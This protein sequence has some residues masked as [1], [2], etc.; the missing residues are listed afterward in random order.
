[1]T[2]YEVLEIIQNAKGK[3][4]TTKQIAKK[5]GRKHHSL[6]HTLQRVKTFKGVYFK[7][8]KLNSY[9]VGFY[10]YKEN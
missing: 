6:S 8:N 2:Q 5:L 7:I 10:K 1:M 9:R 3:W 4:I